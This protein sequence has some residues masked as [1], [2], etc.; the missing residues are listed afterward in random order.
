MFRKFHVVFVFLA[1]VLALLPSVVGATAPGSGETP[2]FSIF[3]PS[4]GKPTPEM[5]QFRIGF[6]EMRIVDVGDAFPLRQNNPGDIVIP[7]PDV[8]MPLSATIFGGIVF[9][10]PGGDW[11]V[12]SFQKGDE[13]LFRL[14]LGY[15]SP[16]LIVKMG[17]SGTLTMS[18]GDTIF[19]LGDTPLVID[20]WNVTHHLDG[21]HFQNGDS[22]IWVTNVGDQVVFEA[23]IPVQKAGWYG[24][25]GYA[26]KNHQFPADV[27]GCILGQYT[28][29]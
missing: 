4:V 29:E 24:C 15:S 19:I 1:I 25:W 7:L 5:V 8:T 28:P 12:A 21:L 22:H 13:E 14:N 11:N 16:Y 2:K 10:V 6:G 26:L 18:Q 17:E 3:I 27:S 9:P 20:G 23:R